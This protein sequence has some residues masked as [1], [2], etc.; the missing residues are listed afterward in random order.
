MAKLKQKVM[1]KAKVKMLN[2]HGMNGPMLVELANSY[3]KALNDGE[4]PVIENAWT[5]VCHFEQE[6]AFKEA[7]TCY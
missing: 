4:V 5:N 1:I 6:R 3:I 2:G 7:V